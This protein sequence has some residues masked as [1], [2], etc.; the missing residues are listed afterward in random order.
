LKH[1]PTISLRRHRLSG[2]LAAAA[3]VAGV[4][5]VVFA[6]APAAS[7][8]PEFTVVAVGSDT[9]QDVYNQFASD[10]GGTTLASYNATNPITGQTGDTIT[11]IDATSGESCSFPRPNGST[12]GLDDLEASIGGTVGSGATSPLPATGC[13]D[14]AR[15]SSG[16]NAEGSGAAG[17]DYTGTNA[18]Q[19]VPFG[20]DALTGAVGPSTGGTSFVAES[21]D[22][23][24][25]EITT[26]TVATA[27]PVATVDTFTVADLTDLFTDCEEVTVGTTVFWPFGDTV[28]GQ[29]T[30]PTGSQR[31]DLY[32]PQEASLPTAPNSS[33]T[34]KFWAS[35]L[36]FNASIPPACDNTTIVNGPLAPTNDGGIL[37]SVKESDGTAVATDEYGYAPFSIAQ[38]ISQSNGHDDRRHGAQLT[39]IVNSSGTQEAPTQVVAGTTELNPSFP[40]TR[41]VYSV[42]SLS[43]LTNTNDVLNGLLD[44]TSSFIC[45]DTAEIISY[46]FL[47]LNNQN[48]P[49]NTCGEITPA[50]EAAP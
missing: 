50:L 43:R 40:I 32:I 25:D 14:I 16:P 10:L 8:D 18:I 33:A 38:W 1:K 17:G 27:L 48:T 5:G 39:D 46:G 21:H 49:G 44:G 22:A 24:G 20:E 41:L 36:G 4:S 28:S 34:G 11:T 15:S 9:V 29:T 26:D 47:P 2:A 19:F 35:T 45:R 7:A 6:S 13:I 12:P 42:V 23:A 37:F 31:I 30:Q 3:L